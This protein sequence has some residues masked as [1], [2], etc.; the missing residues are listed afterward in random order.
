MERRQL[1]DRDRQP[2]PE[3]QLAR[4]TGEG[5]RGVRVGCAVDGRRRGDVSDAG[6]REQAYTV[7]FTDRVSADL[8]WIQCR[9]RQCLA[10]PLLVLQKRRRY[11]LRTPLAMG[12]QTGELKLSL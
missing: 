5:G 8:H 2:L 7:V 10:F 3:R 9:A 1:T 4:A 12:R 11:V 6:Q